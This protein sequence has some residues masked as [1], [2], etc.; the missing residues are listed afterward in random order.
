MIR[1]RLNIATED[2]IEG[3][4]PMMAVESAYPN[5]LK[6]TRFHRIVYAVIGIRPCNPGKSYSIRD[7]VGVQTKQVV[8][9]GIVGQQQARLGTCNGVAFEAKVKEELYMVSTN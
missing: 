1:T 6:K 4:K 3:R 2:T 7:P 8:V 5:T 9:R